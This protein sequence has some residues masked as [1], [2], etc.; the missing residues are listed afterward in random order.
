MQNK[1]FKK[2]IIHYDY[3]LVKLARKLRNNSTFSELLLWNVIKNKQL[4]GYKFLRQ[5]PIDKYIKMIEQVELSQ[6]DIRFELYRLKSVI[7][8]NNL[9][10]SIIKK[11]IC[12][13]LEGVDKDN[14]RILLN[15]LPKLQTNL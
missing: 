7:T 15:A 11:G 3:K 5:K 1:S 12:E 10:T 8:E 6:I 14:K 9:L 13:P 4:R 2:R